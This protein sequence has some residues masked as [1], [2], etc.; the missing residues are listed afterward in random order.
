MSALTATLRKPRW[1]AA[2]VVGVLVAIVSVQLGF[3]QLRRLD[4]RLAR[5]A[6]I[7]ARSDEP[8][9]PL[10]DLR[11]RYSDDPD[12]LVF[13]RAA[14]EGEYMVDKEFVS[15]GRVYGSVAGTLV[16]TPVD[17]GGG[18]VLI[19]VRGIVPVGTPGPPVVGY[20]V[21]RSAVDLEGR[22]ALGEAPSRIGQPNPDDGTISQV[23]RVDLSFVDEWIDGD[24]LPYM[25]LLD[26]QRPGGPGADPTPIPSEELSEGSHLGYAVQWFAFAVIA[27]GGAVGL[28]WRASQASDPSEPDRVTRDT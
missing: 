22:I 24:V 3:W 10:A 6:T 1:I 17:I 23:S 20:D 26:S 16:A 25:L 9:R 21:P 14:V 7:V 19:V 28:V 13:R 4:E 15:V 2:V 8:V 5:N 27:L 18:D 12:A 11:V